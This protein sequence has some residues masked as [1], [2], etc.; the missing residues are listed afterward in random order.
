MSCPYKY[1]FGVPE[2]GF[3]ATRLFGFAVND[4]LGTIGLALI[5][6]YFFNIPVWKSLV[7]M[8]VLGEVL[9]YLFGTQTAFLTYI[10]VKA[11]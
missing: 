4:T 3:H 8:F 6:T 10:G 9:H 1:I 2:K 11:C 7:G 5:G